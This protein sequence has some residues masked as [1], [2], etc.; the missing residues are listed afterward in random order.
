MTGFSTSTMFSVVERPTTYRAI[1]PDI[2]A[3]TDATIWSMYDFKSSPSSFD[4]LYNFTLT[5]KKTKVN[6]IFT[7]NIFKCIEK[8]ISVW[9]IAC[10]G[11][12]VPSVPP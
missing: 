8:P 10:V 12:A 4:K 1:S 3:K 6:T 9:R 5:Y 11:N 7:N 2:T